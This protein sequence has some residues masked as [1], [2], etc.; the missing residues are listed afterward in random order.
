MPCRDGGT[1]GAIDEGPGCWD[2][3]V[4][5]S[6]GPSD[7]ELASVLMPS[8]K[9]Q[10][11][12][13]GRPLPCRQRHCWGECPRWRRPSAAEATE[14][15]QHR[16]CSSRTG[17]GRPETMA[18]KVEVEGALMAAEARTDMTKVGVGPAEILALE[19]GGRIA[20]G[21]LSDFRFLRHRRRK[22][23]GRSRACVF[24]P[25]C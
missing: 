18:C 9:A 14:T 13:E 23:M 16:W 1:S 7:M 24:C 6:R 17:N 8:H 5:R 12:G 4:S 19:E 10:Q 15:D 22:N 25:N 20:S 11:D 3:I 2:N 21:V